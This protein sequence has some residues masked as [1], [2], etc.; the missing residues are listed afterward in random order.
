MNVFNYVNVFR[1]AIE[2]NII[3]VE[4]YTVEYTIIKPKRL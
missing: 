1:M 2:Y 3:E 4:K